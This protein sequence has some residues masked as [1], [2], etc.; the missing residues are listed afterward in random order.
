MKKNLIVFGGLLFSAILILGIVPFVYADGITGNFAA[1]R[2]G[3]CQGGNVCQGDG[4]CHPK[5]SSVREETDSSLD[6][7]KDA[8]SLG[9][10]LERTSSGAAPRGWKEV[11]AAD[12][13]VCYV[14]AT[15]KAMTGKV[16]ISGEMTQEKCDSYCPSNIGTLSSSSKQCDCGPAEVIRNG[17]TFCTNLGNQKVCGELGKQTTANDGSQIT[18]RKEKT[19]SFGQ[20][21]ILVNIKESTDSL[22]YK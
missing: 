12:D 15:G 17:R 14:K 10:S 22:S 16:I 8:K 6:S 1:C 7:S 21:R 19:G 3:A 4:L 9:E 13:G 2:N 5:S 20:A 11:K 18:F